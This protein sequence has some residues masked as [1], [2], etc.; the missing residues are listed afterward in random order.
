MWRTFL[1][2][3]RTTR[4]DHTC[5][6]LILSRTREGGSQALE[7]FVLMP[8]GVAGTPLNKLED[9]MDYKVL[10]AIAIKSQTYIL[11]GKHYSS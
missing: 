8:L 1:C 7:Q 4:T 9:V 5:E 6:L 11:H 3:T 2:R 10:P